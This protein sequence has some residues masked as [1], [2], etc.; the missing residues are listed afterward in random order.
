MVAKAGGRA[1]F[2]AKGAGVKD[3]R[4]NLPKVT[5]DLRKGLKGKVKRVRD[6]R[7]GLWDLERRVQLAGS[8]LGK[9]DP[10]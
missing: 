1:S 6:R 10:A 4:P 8:V 2:R 3:L 5:G 7:T 9:T